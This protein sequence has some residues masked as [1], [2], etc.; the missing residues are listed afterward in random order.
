M[1]SITQFILEKLD[2]SRITGLIRHKYKNEFMISCKRTFNTMDA[3]KDYIYECASKVFENVMYEDFD[4]TFG[5]NKYSA[6]GDCEGGFWDDL[7]GENTKWTTSCTLTFAQL[8]LFVYE[9]AIY[10][11]EKIDFDGGYSYV[12]YILEHRGDKYALMTDNDDACVLGIPDT[13]KLK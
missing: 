6:F 13:L 3:F 7:K 1:K 8:P 9:S 10:K 2:K 5:Q 12:Y 4:K 11:T